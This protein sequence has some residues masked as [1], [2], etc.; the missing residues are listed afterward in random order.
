[1]LEKSTQPKWPRMPGIY[2]W[3]T[4]ALRASPLTPLGSLPEGE[5]GFAQGGSGCP[6]EPLSPGNMADMARPSRQLWFIDHSSPPRALLKVTPL[7]GRTGLSLTA[8]QIQTFQGAV[9]QG[10]LDM[11]LPKHLFFCLFVCLSLGNLDFYG[12]WQPPPRD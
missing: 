7:T 4:E 6:R 12:C 5:N 2:C 9:P 8:L 11:D 1:M 3:A 10:N